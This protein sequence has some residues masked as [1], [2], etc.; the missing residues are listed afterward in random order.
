[1][2]LLDLRRRP[3]FVELMLVEYEVDSIDG[4]LASAVNEI[5]L[6]SVIWDMGL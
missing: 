6:W 2:I 5:D 3:V 4:S 1:M